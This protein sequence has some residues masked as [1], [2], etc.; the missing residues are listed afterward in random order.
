VLDLFSGTG[1]ISIEFASRG[2]Q[3]VDLVESD[4][5][6]FLLINKAI[7][8]LGLNKIRTIKGDAFKF[9]DTCKGKYDVIFADPPYDLEGIDKLPE[10]IFNKNLLLSEGWFIFEHSK[11]YNFKNHPNFHDERHY[12]A[13]HFS[14][15]VNNNTIK[16]E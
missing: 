7:Q 3:Q 8:Q 11:K 10:T 16:D 12:G 6:N 2:S 14:I 9:I 1:S 15:F 4:H 13:V 5:K